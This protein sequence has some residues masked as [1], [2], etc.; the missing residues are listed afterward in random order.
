[1]STINCK[2]CRMDLEKNEM[3]LA[4]KTGKDKEDHRRHAKKT[5]DYILDDIYF[6]AYNNKNKVFLRIF[7]NSEREITLVEIQDAFPS[8]IDELKKLTNALGWFED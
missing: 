3:I 1:M 7:N 4:M 8:N 5:N 2:N 6:E